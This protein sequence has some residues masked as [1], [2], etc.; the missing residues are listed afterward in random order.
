MD[1]ALV[2]EGAFDSVLNA[3]GSDGGIGRTQGGSFVNGE[4]TGNIDEFYYFN[5]IALTGGQIDG[6]GDFGI[7]ELGDLTLNAGSK[8][9][10]NNTGTEAKFDQ[11]TATGD[12]TIDGSTTL[13]LSTI[14]VDSGYTLTIDNNLSGNGALTKSGAGDLVLS[15]T[16][17][18]TGGL[19]VSNGRIT[20]TGSLYDG[21]GNGDLQI[22]SGGTL[23]LDDASIFDNAL[24]SSNI[25][26]GG[27]LAVGSGADGGSFSF[28][29]LTLTDDSI[30]DFAGSSM[31]LDFSSL[32]LA[33]NSLQI[34]NYN[35]NAV[36]GNGSEQLIFGNDLGLVES[37]QIGFFN[38]SPGSSLGGYSRSLPDG[39][40]VPVPEPATYVTG[41][42]LV[43]LIAGHAWRR[44][45]KAVSG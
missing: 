16:N 19:N 9:T 11:V 26:L 41:A 22:A 32:D 23:L 24:G 36:I 7:A 27:T 21:V 17:D 31:I 45:K 44:R 33:G 38:G 37:D 39:E 28:G 2:G 8:A 30:I 43:L 12:S 18:F 6:F 4:F 14:D 35:G 42:G 20:V 13:Q 29:T 15:G 1:G 10:I 25:S 3:H 34:W 40:V 5:D